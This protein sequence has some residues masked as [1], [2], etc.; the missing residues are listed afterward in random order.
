MKKLSPLLLFISVIVAAQPLVHLEP[1]HVP[2]F[3]NASCRILDV[4]ASPGD[5]TEF[6][7]HQNDIVYVT[8]L[9]SEIWLQEFNDE[10]RTV[11]L[12]T[13]WIGSNITHDEDPFIHRFANVGDSYFRLLAVEILTNKYE[14]R[15]FT[16]LGEVLHENDR[17]SI[18]SLEKSS[19]YTTTPLVLIELSDVNEPLG[20]NFLKP[21]KKTF[22]S[23]NDESG[24]FIVIQ[25]K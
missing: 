6:H 21:K 7:I 23:K 9:G 22:L 3:Q 12:P 8:L 4:T 11:T 13:K 25:F 17:F 14:D 2:I 18:Q 5:T 15:T 19:I 10:P 20:I 16:E 1:H 24:Y